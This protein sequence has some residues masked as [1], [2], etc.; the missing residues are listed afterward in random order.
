MW[1]DR[2]YSCMI[3]VAEGSWQKRNSL[4]PIEVFMQIQRRGGIMFSKNAKQGWRLLNF[5][6]SLVARVFKAKYFP[7]SNFL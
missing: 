2:E 7:E 4:V 5:P 6:N 3:L 1:K